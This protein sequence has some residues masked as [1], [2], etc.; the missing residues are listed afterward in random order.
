MGGHV[1]CIGKGEVHTGFCWGKQVERD[2]LQEPGVDGRKILRRIFGKWD[3]GARTGF[4]WL[5]IGTGSGLL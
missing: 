3:G 2:H 4:I 5:R 1:A